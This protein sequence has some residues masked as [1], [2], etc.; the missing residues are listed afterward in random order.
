MRFTFLRSNLV[1]N[2]VAI[3]VALFHC[4]CKWIIKD[5]TWTKGWEH[6]LQF[7]AEAAQKATTTIIEEQAQ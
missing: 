6:L 2:L 3:Y 7:N 1:A 5:S 4:L